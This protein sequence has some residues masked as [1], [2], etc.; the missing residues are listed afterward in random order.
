MNEVFEAKRL[1]LNHFCKTCGWC[2]LAEIPM[3]DANGNMFRKCI[4]HE[5]T[6][7][8]KI[9]P[10]KSVSSFGYCEWWKEKKE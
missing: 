2:F 3:W 6:F 4:S 5:C 9:Q 8:A 7:D 1:L 10:L